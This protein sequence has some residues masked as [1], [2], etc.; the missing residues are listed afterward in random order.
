M[1]ARTQMG[2]QGEN[3][4]IE[5]NEIGRMIKGDT[6]SEPWSWFITIASW[7]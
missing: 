1:R 6:L 3:A 4:Y 7:W 2:L 5:K